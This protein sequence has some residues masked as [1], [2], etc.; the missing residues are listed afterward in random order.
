MKFFT[1]VQHIHIY[2]NLSLFEGLYC[3]HGCHVTEHMLLSTYASFRLKLLFSWSRLVLRNVLTSPISGLDDE[4]SVY[5]LSVGE[6]ASTK[7][8]TCFTVDPQSL[9]RDT[10]SFSRQRLQWPTTSVLFLCCLTPSSSQIVM[11]R[12]CCAKILGYKVNPNLSTMPPK[13]SFFLKKQCALQLNNYS[14][15]KLQDQCIV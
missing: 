14:N 10:R 11:L 4:Q 8:G 1:R 12:F 2:L 9:A 7:W 13:D 5:L 3:F 6:K 15:L